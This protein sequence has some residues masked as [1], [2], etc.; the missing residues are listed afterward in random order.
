MLKL[1]LIHAGERR[2]QIIATYPNAAQCGSWPPPVTPRTWRGSPDVVFLA[3]WELSDR[4]DVHRYVW[5]VRTPPCRRPRLFPL[6]TRHSDRWCRQTACKGNLEWTSS[7]LIC[8]EGMCFSWMLL[9]NLDI[10]LQEVHVMRNQ[11]SN[12]P[13]TPPAEIINTPFE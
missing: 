8:F 12:W 11:T 5:A 13:I 9:I 2:S 3:P 10:W 6:C 7:L 1:K 4:R